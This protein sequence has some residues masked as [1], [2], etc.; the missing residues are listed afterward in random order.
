MYDRVDNGSMIESVLDLLKILVSSTKL[1][2]CKMQFAQIK[3]ASWMDFEAS[4]NCFHVEQVLNTIIG[5]A[6]QG[7]IGSISAYT[8]VYSQGGGNDRTA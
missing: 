4:K 3:K 5:F 2:L 1:F 8:K 6:A 7:R